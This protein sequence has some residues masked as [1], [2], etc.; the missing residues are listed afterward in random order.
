M[1]ISSEKFSEQFS[2]IQQ[3]FKEWT[4]FEQLCTIV[5]LTRTFQSSYHYFLLQLLQVNIQYENDDMF[6]HTVD[7]ANAPDIVT[8]L[9]SNSLDKILFTIQLYLPLISTKTINDKLL[10][11]YRDVLIYLDSNIL[12]AK[13]FTYPEQQIINL[14]QQILF[15]I[16]ANKY[17]QKL[18]LHIP[19]LI[20]LVQTN[21]FNSD[22]QQQQCHQPLQ[23]YSSIR[24]QVQPLMNYSSD[25]SSNNITSC[26]Q[27]TRHEINDSG[28][29]LTEPS[30]ANPL[31]N[32]L[33]TQ[34][35][36][37]SFMD[38][39]H[40]T[41]LSSTIDKHPFVAKTAS[42]PIPEHA[43][44][45][46]PNRI[47]LTGVLSAPS[48]TI[49]TDYR[50][51][52]SNYQ[53]QK[54]KTLLTKNEEDEQELQKSNEDFVSEQ[55]NANDHAKALT[56]FYSLRYP[57]TK[58]NQH[59]DDVSQ[60]LGVDANSNFAQ[61][62]FVQ[63]NTGMRDVPKWLKHL[64]LHKYDV[65]FSKMT[66]DQMMN[67]TIEEL[68]ELR[69]TDGACTKILLNI[70]KLKERS[71][72][73]KQCLTDIDDGQ[74]DLQNFV[75]QLNELMITPIRSKQLEQENNNEEDLPSLIMQV[76]EKIYQQLSPNSS[77]DISNS[78]LGLF[79]RC[80]RHEAFT[81][82]QRHILLQW[83]RRLSNTLQSL[84][85][86]EYKTIQSAFIHSS[87]QR[88][89]GKPPIRPVKSATNTYYPNNILNSIPL[90]KNKSEPQ[91]N[92]NNNHFIESNLIQRPNKSPTLIYPTN[93]ESNDIYLQTS[94][95]GITS[96]PQRNNGAYLA[97]N[98]HQVLTRKASI[99]PYDEIN[100]NNNKTKLCQTFSDP[101]RK[102]FNNS[103]QINHM[104]I[105]SSSIQ[106]QNLFR[107]TSTPYSQ[108]QRHFI[109]RSPP[110]STTMDI[111]SS[112][113][114]K[115]YSDNETSNY[116]GNNNNNSTL[117]SDTN[118]AET[119]DDQRHHNKDFESLCL[120]ITESAISDDIHEMSIDHKQE[121]LD[122]SNLKQSSSNSADTEQ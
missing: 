81:D 56:H 26:Q 15:F 117:L 37:H 108:Q 30:I 36:Q 68:K 92:N 17:L 44:I 8:C 91:N 78:L 73:L 109:S 27:L 105:S 60:Y 50:H 13:K 113:I 82:D 112:P 45:N 49:Y 51:K 86:I 93:E 54:H 3:Q 10:D 83:R 65:F 38:R 1:C 32:F 21:K 80:Y 119:T 57:N 66:Y 5:E 46:L 71:I 62:T 69:I 67:L 33:S 120:Q 84:G 72:I 42:S 25:G 55:N 48:S 121:I 35:Q 77:P 122:I 64:R 104:Q 18:S 114:K 7:D 88:R 107:I 6:N 23:R 19:Q 43:T 47:P 4:P 79:D 100:S 98:Q 115:C 11:A 61:N 31:Q 22:E 95:T 16:Q 59:K 28:V 2:R 9:L 63:P 58:I 90:S 40:R 118:Y 85:K 102:R 14:S 96:T 70:K 89:T 76:L 116:Y 20:K 41:N 110:T 87:Q 52:N 106:Q 99:N 34:M 101:S 75:Q 39:S 12:N 24:S 111:S 29:D 97:N 103:T 53:Q 74:I 94:F